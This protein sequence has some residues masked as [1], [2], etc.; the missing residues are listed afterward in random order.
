MHPATEFYQPLK[1]TA[2]PAVF[3]S[4][5]LL[6]G[7]GPDGCVDP[8]AELQK[9]GANLARANAWIRGTIGKIES[10]AD[11]A[12]IVT[13]GDHGAFLSDHCDDT[14]PDANSGDAIVDSLGVLLAVKWPIHYDGRYDDEIHSLIDFS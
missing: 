2:L 13:M 10:F 4:H 14:D 11:D 1:E 8:K 3:Y 9:C 12:I 6:P 7:H 5:F